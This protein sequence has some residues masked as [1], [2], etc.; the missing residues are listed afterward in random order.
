[1]ASAGEL[2]V[3]VDSEVADAIRRIAD[4]LQANLEELRAI[5]VALEPQPEVKMDPVAATNSAQSVAELRAAGLWR[6]K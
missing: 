2:V 6:S 1:M 5:R 4:L 3:R